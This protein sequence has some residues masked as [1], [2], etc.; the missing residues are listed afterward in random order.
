MSDPAFEAMCEVCN[1]DWQA[2]LTNDERGRANAALK[3]LRSIYADD[4]ALPQM[5]FERAAAYR[6]VY[7]EIALTPQALTGAWSSILGQMEEQSVRESA[8]R[9]VANAP[10]T[11]HGCICGGDHFVIVGTDAKGYDI[12]GP[13]PECGPDNPSYYVQG[14]LIRVIDKGESREMLSR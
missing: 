2:G 6:V 3:Q 1:I 7:P 10:T 5:I 12:A 13:C 8:K 4:H 11:T 14:K 9:R